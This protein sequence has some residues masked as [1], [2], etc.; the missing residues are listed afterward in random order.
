MPHRLTALLWSARFC[1]RPLMRADQTINPNL[2]G[3][4]YYRNMIKVLFG[5]FLFIEA[6]V[7][8][9]TTHCDWRWHTNKSYSVLLRDTFG[10][11]GFNTISYL[12]IL[13]DKKLFIWLSTYHSLYASSV[14]CFMAPCGFGIADWYGRNQNMSIRVT[15]NGF[16]LIILEVS[17]MSLF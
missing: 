1:T 4:S 5:L 15:R 9:V 7:N 14:V 11:I 16:G 12:G 10:Q 17:G 6:G 8:A 2:S 13:K 3:I